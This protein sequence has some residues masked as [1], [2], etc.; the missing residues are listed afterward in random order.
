MCLVNAASPNRNRTSICVS[1]GLMRAV[2]ARTRDESAKTGV[3]RSGSLRSGRRALGLMTGAGTTVNMRTTCMV[4][5]NNMKVVR[6]RGSTCAVGRRSSLSMG[7][8]HM[9][10]AA[11]A[12][13]TGVRPGPKDTVRSSFSARFLPAIALGSNR[14][15]GVIAMTGAGQGAGLAKSHMFSVR[16]ARGAP[17]GTVVKFGNS[18]EVAVGS[19]SKVAGSGLRALIAG[20]TTLRTRLCSRK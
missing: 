19:T 15:R 18:T 1:N 4:G 13:A 8:G 7:V 3:F 12:V 2:G 14:S 10:K 11:K 5:G 20:S 9:N 6:L 16:L 17:G